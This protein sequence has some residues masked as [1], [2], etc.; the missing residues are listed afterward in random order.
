[1][2]EYRTS[3]GEVLDQICYRIYGTEQAIHAVLQVNAGLAAYGT[4]LP[5]GL[6]L[7]LP[8]I[9]LQASTDTATLRLWD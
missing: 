9:Q 3:A 4:H 6:L 8:D 7:D 5:E 1:M 2:A